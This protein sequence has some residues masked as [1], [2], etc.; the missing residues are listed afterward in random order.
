VA[1]RNPQ[2]TKS[3]R[4]VAQI[5]LSWWSETER[6]LSPA[7]ILCVLALVAPACSLPQIDGVPFVEIR[8]GEVM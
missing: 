2:E 3:P 5:R 7:A 1:A 8:V 6:R 4:R